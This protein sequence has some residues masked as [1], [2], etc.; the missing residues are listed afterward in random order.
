MDLNIS[1]EEI[2]HISKYLFNTRQNE[3]KSIRG[4]QVKCYRNL[5]SEEVT[6]CKRACGIKEIKTDSFKDSRLRQ[7]R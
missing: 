4:I 1:V 3:I 5:K 7:P 6:S 2:R